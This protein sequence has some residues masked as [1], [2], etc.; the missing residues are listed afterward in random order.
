MKKKTKRAK[1]PRLSASELFASES[2]YLKSSDISKE[3]ITVISGVRAEE[4]DG[5]LKGVLELTDCKDVVVCNTSGRLLAEEF[6]SDDLTDWVGHAVVVYKER[7]RDPS[8]KPCW[9]VRVRAADDDE[10]EDDDEYD[11]DE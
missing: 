1:K 5:K 4:F 3:F 7:T 11:E 8:G 10:D 9:G 6:E 2:A